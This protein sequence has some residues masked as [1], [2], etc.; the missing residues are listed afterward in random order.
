MAA[1]ALRKIP[2]AFI[3][4]QNPSNPAP[5]PFHRNSSTASNT[6][7]SIRNVA[8]R[9][10]DSASSLE[11]NNASA[12]LP[13][14]RTDASHSRQSF[15]IPSK[16]R[17]SRQHPRRPLRSPPLHPRKSV[18]TI[19]H[20]RQIIRNRLRPHSKL[21][22]HSRLVAH[23]ILPP[24]H[25]HHPCP[26]HTLTQIL[27]RRTNKHLP[28]A[29]ISSGPSRSRSQRIIRLNFHHRPYQNAHRRQ[30]LLQQRKL[31]QQRRIHSLRRL[32]SRIKIVPKRL[33]HMIRSDT[34]MRRPALDHPRAPIPELPA[35]RRSPARSRPWPKARQKSSETT[36]Y[37]PSIR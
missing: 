1:T 18:R 22:H 12:N 14:P 24:I 35:P 31:R 25:L 26:H 21:L 23:L 13:A 32:V 9:R 6:G 5:G 7:A 3:R 11:A 2:S 16:W 10:N 28:H 27:I 4:L 37:V 33:H 15:G 30:R 34:Q 17:I 19:P 29:L 20:H 8:S 36:L